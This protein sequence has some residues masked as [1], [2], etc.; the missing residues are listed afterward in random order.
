MDN[1]H[2]N[3]ELML[4]LI[5]PDNTYMTGSCILTYAISQEGNGVEHTLLKLLVH[6]A[7]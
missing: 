1:L 4:L 2:K 3:L 6:V 5:P 7:K